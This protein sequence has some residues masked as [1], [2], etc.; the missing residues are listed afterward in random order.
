[1]RRA[2]GVQT[3]IGLAPG[4]VA[5]AVTALRMHGRSCSPVRRQSVKLAPERRMDGGDRLQSELEVTPGLPVSTGMALAPFGAIVSVSKPSSELEVEVETGLLAPRI[6]W[7]ILQSLYSSRRRRIAWY[8]SGTSISMAVAKKASAFA[9][10]IRLSGA[11]RCC[12]RMSC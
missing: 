6:D 5:G 3:R 4:S 11:A 2:Q 8:C 7:I 10:D 1:M 9:A 12:S